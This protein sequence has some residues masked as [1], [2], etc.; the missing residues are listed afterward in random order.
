MAYQ[1]ATYTFTAPIPN[2]SGYPFGGKTDISFTEAREE[3][4]YLDETDNLFEPGVTTTGEPGQMLL[5]ETVLGGVTLP[6]GSVLSYNRNLVGTIADQSTGQGYYVFF[7]QLAGRFSSELAEIGD[8]T[9]VMIIPMS[10]ATPPFDPTH[11]FEFRQVQTPSSM[12]MAET[13]IP[14]DYLTSICFAAGTLIQTTTGPRPVEDLRAGDL[15]MTRDRGLRP[16]GWTGR[17]RVSARLLD[18]APNLRPIM[19]RKGALGQ[20]MPAQDLIVSPQHRV[21]VRSA[22]AARIAG[23]PEI[24]VAA[25]HL[26]GIAGIQ[27]L[28]A[29]QGIDY[30]HL[31]FDRHELVWSNGCWT[32]S[33]FTGPQALSS[34]GP[35]G[36]REIRA[37]FPQ[38][39]AEDG[40]PKTGARSFVSG[41]DARELTRRHLKNA[42]PLL[43]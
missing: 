41:R 35:A 13:T 18:I 36:R 4:I 1:I 6:E 31:L 15:I 2:S 8:R 5:K 24:L 32:E 26:C 10:P 43:S 23:T 30:H 21:L 14:S 28:P 27:T 29:P 22:I 3:I 9:T 19:I 25:K 20:G 34:I 33:L 42:K 17:R 37:L 38:L 39:L 7:P 16:L 11:L 12:R 40:A